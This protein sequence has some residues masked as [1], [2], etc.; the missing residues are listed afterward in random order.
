V[1]ERLG[2]GNLDCAEKC[3]VEKDCFGQLE[4][5]G[6]KSCTTAAI[7]RFFEAN[8]NVVHP[9][10]GIVQGYLRTDKSTDTIYINRGQFTWWR[11]WSNRGIPKRQRSVI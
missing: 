3:T 6:E 4:K 1:A 2:Y 7:K 11:L 5:S 9:E 8:P 10:N